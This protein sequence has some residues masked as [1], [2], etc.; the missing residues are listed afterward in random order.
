MSA[1]SRSNDRALKISPE[2]E[3]IEKLL[4]VDGF[5]KLNTI[6]ALEP[7]S[8]STAVTLRMNSIAGRFS[9]ILPE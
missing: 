5:A 6:S 4:L 9:W 1:V 2:V 7:E 3:L 8:M